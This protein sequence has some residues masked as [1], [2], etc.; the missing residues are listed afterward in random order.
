M[1]Y[2]VKIP[3]IGGLAERMA[4]MRIWLDNHRVEPA[5]FDH[6]RGGP[7][8]SF[9]LAFNGEHDARDFADAFRGH[10]EP[11]DAVGAAL[12]GVSPVRAEERMQGAPAKN[13]KVFPLIPKA[14]RH[15]VGFGG[16]QSDRRLSAARLQP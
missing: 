1:L 6:S 13:D 5:F 2:T 3:H 4:E 14:A 7:G 16:S 12:W 9:L 8:V 15:P 11:I 10:F